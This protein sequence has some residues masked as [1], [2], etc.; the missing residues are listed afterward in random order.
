M[1]A[2]HEPGSA[3]SNDSADSKAEVVSTILEPLAA[4]G[5]H[6]VVPANT[7]LEFDLSSVWWIVQ[8]ACNFELS[9]HPILSLEAGDVVGPWASPGIP[10]ALSTR[11]EASCELIGFPLELI[12]A[13]LSKDARRSR[14]WAQ[15]QS[16]LCS[17]LFTAFVDLKSRL[18]APIP[19]HKRF[20]PGETIILEGDDGDEVFVLTKGGAQVLLQGAKVGEVHEDEVF[21]ALAALTDSVRTATVVADR[22]CECMIFTRDEFRDLLRTNPSLLSK[23]F[24]DFGRALHDLNDTVL[25]ASYTKWR[26]LF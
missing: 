16:D 25:K 23:L 1:S 21:G 18:V 6:R 15:Y 7:T 24:C 14:L 4:H 22:P 3:P 11:N 19:R 2:T 17:E 12:L 8:G 10:L 26:N 5:L 20:E 13:D 9:G